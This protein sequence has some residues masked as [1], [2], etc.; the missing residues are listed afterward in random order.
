MPNIKSKRIHHAIPVHYLKGFVELDGLSYIWEYQKNKPFDRTSKNGLT[1]NPYRKHV[2]KAGAFKDLYAVKDTA[3]PDFDTYEEKIK[4]LED[5]TI[6]ILNKIR[7]YL[8]HNNLTK[9]EK[10]TLSRYILLLI[11]RVPTEQERQLKS[12]WPVALNNVQDR[13]AEML[14]DYADK[15]DVSDLAQL[16]RYTKMKDEAAKIIEQFRKAIP[17]EIRLQAMIRES[18]LNFAYILSNMTWQFFVA[19]AR[20]EFFTNDNPVYYFREYGINKI[21]SELSFPISRKVCLV[22]SWQAVAEG[23]FQATAAQVGIINERTA[24]RAGQ[25]L[26][27]ATAS[28][29]VYDYAVRN[30]ENTN[31]I[32]L[33]YPPYIMYKNIPRLG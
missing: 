24:R 11:K 27:A 19:S 15:L 14:E 23:Y 3:T 12:A 33:L 6:P 13:T 17:D 30:N 2:R 31:Q 22:A 20:E 8:N 28:K 32:K 21:F 18:D 29:T 1:Q 25:F 26:Y 9:E 16:A 10:Y 5:E 7:Q 4:L